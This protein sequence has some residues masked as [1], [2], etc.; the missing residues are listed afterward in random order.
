MDKMRKLAVYLLTVGLSVSVSASITDDLLA[1]RAGRTAAVTPGV[2]HSDL[3]KARD[4]AVANGLPLVAV[5]SNGEGCAHCVA[6]ENC[7]MS[8]AFRHW[9]KDSGIVFY[10]G[11][12]SDAYDGQEGYHG[13]SFFWCCNNRNT[14][15]NWPYVRVYW[16]KGGVDHVATGAWYDGEEQGKAMRS[17]YIDNRTDLENLIAPGD[18]GT[19]NPGGR[20]I[21]S[22]LVGMETALAVMPVGGGVA[23]G[24]LLAGFSAVTYAGGEFGFVYHPSY[25]D[26]GAQVEYGTTMKNLVIPLTREDTAA[27]TKASYN[28][29]RTVYPNGHAETNKV[30]WA[31]GVSATNAVVKLDSSWL[32]G[33]SGVVSLELYSE[34]VE[35]QETSK[36]WCVEK[37]PNSPS[38]PL[39]IGERT[40]STLGW[41]EWTMDVSAAIDKVKSAGGSTNNAYV[42]VVCSGSLWCPDCVKTDKYLFDTDAFKEWSTN[43]HNVALAA[44]DIPLLSTTYPDGDRACL[45]SSVVSSVS[46]GYMAALGHGEAGRYQCGVAYQTRHGVTQADAASVLARNKTYAAGLLNK[47]IPTNPYRPGVPTIYALRPDGTIA[48][49]IAEFA[50]VSP[51]ASSTNYISRLEEL[52]ALVDEEAEERKN[53]LCGSGNAIMSGNERVGV[54][55]TVSLSDT[56]DV[57]KLNAQKGS[58]LVLSVSG[59]DDAT[60]V[61]SVLDGSEDSIVAIATN[62]LAAGMV[63]ECTLAS[64]NCYVS[65]AACQVLS[66]KNLVF[67]GTYFDP[68]KDGSTVAHYTIKTDSVIAPGEEYNEIVIADCSGGCSDLG[69]SATNVWV[70][71]ESGAQYKFDGLLEGSA[72]NATSLT[73]DE[74]SD[75]YTSKVSG[76]ARLVLVPGGDG[77]VVFGYQRWVPGVIEF[78]TSAQTIKERGDTEEYDVSY[79]ISVRRSGGVSGMGGVVVSL[80]DE[81]STRPVDTYEWIY[82]EPSLYWLDGM[83]DVQTA[84]VKI[85]ADTHA[86]GTTKLVFRLL[87]VEGDFEFDAA[88]SEKKFTLTIVDE[89]VANEGRVALVYANDIKIPESRGITAVGGSSCRLG[90]ERVE[91]SDGVVE[92]AVFADGTNQVG[93]ARWETRQGSETNMTVEVAV[94]EYVEGGA[95]KTRLSIVGVAGTKVVPDDKYLTINVIPSDAAMFATGMA[96]VVDMSRYVKHDSI[97]VELDGTTV[98]GENVEI[99]KISG[100]VAPGMEWSGTIGASLCSPGS[101]GLEITGTP[102]KGGKYTAVFQVVQDGVAGGTVTVTMTVEDPVEASDPDSEAENPYLAATRTVS[103]IMVVD[104][105]KERLVGLLT[106][107]VPRNGRLSGKYRSIDGTTVSLLSTEWDSCT[108]GNYVAT[109]TGVQDDDVSAVVTANADGTIAVSLSLDSEDKYDCLYSGSEWS[110]ENPATAWEGY[111][112]VSLPFIKQSDK[113]AAFANGDGY[114]TLKMTEDIAVN[115]GRMVYAGILPNGKAFSGVA[116]LEATSATK[117]LIPVFSVSKTDTATGVLVV[118]KSVK[119][120]EV[121]PH[122]NAYPYWQ[123]DDK[124][125]AASYSGKLNAYGCLYGQGEIFQCC[126]NTFATQ[127]LT[128][129]ALP[130]EMVDNSAFGTRATYYADC[131]PVWSTN[132]IHA[133]AV[134]IYTDGTNDSISLYDS[135]RAKDVHGLTLNFNPVT[136]LVSGQL[137][138][139]FYETSK[140]GTRV[141]ATYRGVVKPGWG[142]IPAFCSSCTDITTPQEAPFISGTCYFADTFEY[143]YN[144]NKRWLQITRG[145]RF[146]IG[147][148]AGN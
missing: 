19:Y 104:T 78:L 114:V 26:G 135:S 84:T 90:L 93:T 134:K 119:Y 42:L 30:I 40:A 62:S 46:D 35:L 39:F 56:V 131:K 137:W 87:P 111:Y 142:K 109:M 148:E 141:L 11:V 69:D 110:E 21:I 66:G 74:K 45:L 82:P 36:I 77:K 107:T 8:A 83:S 55:G 33:S 138:L 121:T 57:Y 52:L 51:T 136:G 27:Q 61:V 98:T 71:L 14:S 99:V 133:V 73:Y 41:G 125:D 102:T 81:E 3:N 95:N 132:D 86:D 92:V 65:V 105:E 143:E 76:K 89:G 44:I 94:P 54:S 58:D 118:D 101:P 144:L 48:G 113:A 4:Y 6:F 108:N 49:R 2:W 75:V 100:S 25:P 68:A 80:V 67:T 72:V 139:D 126:T 140:T 15:M 124:L 145:C 9:M 29:L 23:T 17:M 22:V 24:G 47:L 7:V 115:S 5:W 120:R 147:V 37:V 130:G 117:A 34:S 64:S 128:F 10:F 1:I 12:R 43:T 129:F 28:W 70:K 50:T 122:E 123:H 116:T 127:Y 18:Y 38:N 63:L 60:V 146:S 53:G 59:A 32:E 16:P 97:K 13:T 106:I 112:T 31:V 96:A 79:Q 103:D 88:I 91:G 20:R 85:K